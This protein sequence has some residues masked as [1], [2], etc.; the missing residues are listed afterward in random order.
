MINTPRHVQAVFSN[1]QPRYLN[2][3][4]N[5][6]KRVIIFNVIKEDLFQMIHSVHDFEVVTSA[7]S[8]LQVTEIFN[9]EHDKLL[10]FVQS[11]GD[12]GELLQNL[13][14][15]Q[16]TMIFDLMQNKLCDL[17]KNSTCYDFH[18]LIGLLLP[19]QQS[20][21][22][23]VMIINLSEV[24]LYLEDLNTFNALYSALSTTQCD[25]FLDNMIDK[26]V[27]VVNDKINHVVRCKF[28]LSNDQINQIF[29]KV[30]GRIPTSDALDYLLNINETLHNPSA[31][32]Y[33]QLFEGIIN[34]LSDL[35]PNAE[36]FYNKL[37]H[38]SLNL[39]EFIFN[40]M[41]A[42]FSIMVK[43]PNDLALILSILPQKSYFFLDTPMQ[44]VL[45][46]HFKPVISDESSRLLAHELIIN[47]S[48]N[49]KMQFNNII[50][51]LTK[52]NRK[53]FTFYNTPNS[54][55]VFIDC[56]CELATNN[57]YWYKNI[58]K[59][60]ELDIDLPLRDELEKYVAQQ[61]TLSSYINFRI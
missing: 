5:T 18:K 39:R 58:C 29:T 57:N 43:T 23:D 42:N 53:L 36:I 46:N 44:V 40:A 49:I 54:A 45:E 3:S 16:R 14:A 10:N 61:N 55:S 50:G 21:V 26:L 37:Q 25:L 9:H 30:K 12:L 35:I 20:I 11:I 34:Q 2:S 1:L 33:N 51:K 27:Y 47:N 60:L 15:S 52:S 8:S 7:M 4:L 13:D 17:I 28:K 22:M 56:I 59:A 31:I 38:V 6:D 48:D 41:R 32:E 19:Q 24:D